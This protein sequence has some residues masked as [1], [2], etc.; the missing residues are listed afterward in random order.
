MQ[1]GISRPTK[2]ENDTEIIKKKMTDVLT[3]DYPY[4]A[5]VKERSVLNDRLKALDTRVLLQALMAKIESLMTK[6]KHHKWWF[7][8]GGCVSIGLNLT[9]LVLVIILMNQ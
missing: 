6:L 8:V 9:L 7:V 1:L 4:G 2:E 5:M 3:S